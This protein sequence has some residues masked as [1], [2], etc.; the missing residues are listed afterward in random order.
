MNEINYGNFYNRL[1]YLQMNIK[2]T[3]KKCYQCFR[4]NFHYVLVHAKTTVNGM[5]EKNF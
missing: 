2:V 4:I 1:Y 5:P 3:R